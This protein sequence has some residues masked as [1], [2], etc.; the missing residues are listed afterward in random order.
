MKTT[1][2][3]EHATTN[4]QHNTTN[5]MQVTTSKCHKTAACKSCTQ[6]LTRCHEQHALCMQIANC[7]T[8]PIAAEM[9]S[10]CMMLCLTI[11]LS[12]C[13]SCCRTPTVSAAQGVGPRARSRGVLPSLCLAPYNGECCLLLCCW[14]YFL[15][16]MLL[17]ACLLLHYHCC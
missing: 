13:A 2:N 6:M 14:L 9:R 3:T 4:N 10:T 15:A 5:S 1:C 7:M 12:I 11:P 16:V 17:A 8:W